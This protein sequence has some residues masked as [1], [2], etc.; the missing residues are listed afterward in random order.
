MNN[1]DTWTQGREHHTWG[2][3]GGTRGETAGGGE[4]GRKCQIQ[5]MG[6]KAANHIEIPS[7]AS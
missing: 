5:V 3:F 4:M 6:R 7:H 2:L 1:E